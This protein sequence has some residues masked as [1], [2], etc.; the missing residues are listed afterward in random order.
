MNGI[1]YCSYGLEHVNNTIKSARSAK[2]HCPDLPVCIFTNAEGSDQIKQKGATKLFEH[3][4]VK[5]KMHRRSKLDY[6][7]ECPFDRTLFLDGDTTI[8]ADIREMFQLLDAFDIALAHAHARN[9]KKTT[10]IWRIELPDSFPQ[11]NSGVFLFK[12]TPEVRAFFEDWRKSYHE[13][14]IRKDQVT[15]REC[16]WKSGLRI[17]TLP[18]EYNLRYKKYLFI[19]RRNEATLKIA[20]YTE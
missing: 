6:F 16:L 9:R 8:K 19:W 18:P 3:I 12:K 4:F 5:E 17:A 10:K 2:K 15:L 11:F 13:A 14:G 1:M 7:N 20:H